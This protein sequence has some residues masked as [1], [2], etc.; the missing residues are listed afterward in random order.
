MNRRDWLCRGLL[1]LLTAPALVDAADDAKVLP[2]AEAKD[3]VDKEI[4]VEIVVK[5]S[6]LLD[7]GAFCFLNSEKSYQEKA[8]FTIAIPG[9]A[10]PKFAALG[11][12]DPASHF[13]GQTIRVTG[14]VSLHKDRPQIVVNDP[15]QILLVAKLVLPPK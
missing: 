14:K 2:V 11:V 12:K 13:Q 1:L 10:L 4:T 15:K 3:H 8:N 9:E 6:R 5:S 7:S